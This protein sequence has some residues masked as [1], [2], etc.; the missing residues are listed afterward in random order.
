[1]LAGIAA[2]LATYGGSRPTGTIGSPLNAG[3]IK[4]VV[5]STVSPIHDPTLG[6]PGKPGA[7]FNIQYGYG[8]PNVLKAMQAVQAAR[9]P[10]VPDISG[11]RWYSLLDP[12]RTRSLPITA[13]LDARRAH[14]F[15]YVVQYG[16]GPD[17][18]E[19][20]FQTIAHGSVNGTSLHGRVAT[21]DLSRIPASFWQ[22]PFG[23]TQDLSSAEQYDVTIRI[24]MTDDHGLMGEDRRAIEVHHDPSLQRGFPIDM[25]IGQ[26][27]QPVMADLDGDGKLELVFGDSNGR[28]HAI[29][30]STGRELPGFPALTRRVDGVLAGTPAARAGAVPKAYE[31]IVAPAAVGDLNGDGKLEVVVTSLDG[32][33]Y[34]FEPNGKLLKGFP[35][36]VGSN[37]LHQGVPAPAE[38]FT[39]P[40]SMGAAAAPMLTRLPGS[41]TKLD[42]VQA[43]WDSKVYA[44]DARGH[45]VPGWP[46]TVAIPDSARSGSG[47]DHVNDAKLLSTPTLANV[48]GDAAPELVVKS[49]QWD[50]QD[51]LTGA[52]GPGV[53][54]RFYE[55]ALW[56][57]GNRHSGG[58]FVPGWPAQ[59]Q[60][61]L[62]YYGTAQDWV[63]EG[64]D[65]PSAAAIDGSGRDS[66]IQPTV[67][68]GAP[69]HPG[70]R[71]GAPAGTAADARAGHRELAR[72]ARADAGGPAAVAHHAR[73]RAHA[74]LRRRARRLHDE[75]R[76]RA[77]R[78]QAAM[79]LGRLRPVHALGPAPARQGHAHHQLHARLRPLERSDGGELPG[80]HDGAGVPHRSGGR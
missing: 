10:P 15:S 11:P 78:R 62:G 19:S 72:R 23:Y 30:P 49:Q 39:R 76:V 3:E 24:Q 68:G 64:G 50:Y 51:G 45:D 1:M 69:A 73:R 5:R 21:L 44:F 42:V 34:A 79:A 65:S 48:A 55:Q 75:R 9:V 35:R 70:R 59:M 7:T 67:F 4:Q 2:L 57:D 60:G 37:A 47:Y 18:T 20:E 80:S 56:A 6:W 71:F 52:G 14:G 66:L 27:S 41:P 13:N 31:P 28:V 61:V 26:E 43:A 54:S 74:G 12:T 77:L 29:R 16:L 33:V 17:P 58:P 53:G 32:R 63:T 22:R 36:T 8:R 40:P 38:P 25:G 46:V